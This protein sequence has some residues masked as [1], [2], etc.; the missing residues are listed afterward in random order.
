MPSLQSLV[1]GTDYPFIHRMVGHGVT[2]IV[3][4]YALG[5]RLVRPRKLPWF[6]HGKSAVE[7]D[8]E[9]GANLGVVFVPASFAVDDSI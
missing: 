3:S 4:R 2:G 9:S 7:A 6:R 1:N 8:D 5:R